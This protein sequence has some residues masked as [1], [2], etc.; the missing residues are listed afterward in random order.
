MWLHT[1]TSRE[2]GLVV[3]EAGATIAS[4]D[5]QLKHHRSPAVHKKVQT[6]RDGTFQFND[7]PAGKY[8][9]MIMSPGFPSVLWRGVKV[10]PGEMLAL[11]STTLRYVPDACSPGPSYLPKIE[12]ARLESGNSQVVGSVIETNEA[13]ALAGASVVVSGGR[14]KI[15]NEQVKT[16]SQGRF[17]LTGL[18]EGSYRLRVSAAGYS[19]FVADLVPVRPSEETRIQRLEMHKCRAGHRCKPTKYSQAWVA[20]Y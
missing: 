20:C 8:D 7:V 5:V 12:S 15:K 4:A 9:V 10:H 14:T 13:Q 2:R 3:N 17:K 16:D 18:P 19:D 11:S 1:A 6:A